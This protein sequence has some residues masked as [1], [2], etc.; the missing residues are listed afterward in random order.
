MTSRDQS[1][2]HLINNRRAQYEDTLPVSRPHQVAMGVLGLS[3]DLGNRTLSA[4]ALL[5]AKVLSLR[6]R[7]ERERERESVCER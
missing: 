1:I 4:A 5:L 3:T 6:S 7:G 2:V